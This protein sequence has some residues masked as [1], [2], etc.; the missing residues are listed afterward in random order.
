MNMIFT[1]NKIINQILKIDGNDRTEPIYCSADRMFLNTPIVQPIAYL[2]GFYCTTSYLMKNDLNGNFL[3]DQ[4][5][6]PFTREIREHAGIG[7]LPINRL[8]DYFAG[9]PPGRKDSY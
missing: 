1:R 5:G 7:V 8:P 6:Q 2:T 3:T 4:P 9:A